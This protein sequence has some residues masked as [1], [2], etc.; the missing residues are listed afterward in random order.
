MPSGLTVKELA[1]HFGV[2]I[3][4]AKSWIRAGLFPNSVLEETPRGPVRRIPRSDVRRF[5][6]PAMG[7]P[8][9]EKSSS[10]QA[11]KNAKRKG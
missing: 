7:R 10:G 2:S 1:E 3:S 6:R 4:T 11:G 9:E 5:K 8:T